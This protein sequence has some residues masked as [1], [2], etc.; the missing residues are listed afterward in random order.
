MNRSDKKDEGFDIVIGNPPYGAKI[1]KDESPEVVSA[2]KQII[3]EEIETYVLFYFKG[4]KLLLNKGT[5]CYITPDSWLTNRSTSLFRKWITETADII[6]IFDYY[7]PFP[8]AKDTRVHS[9]LICIGRNHSETRIKQVFPSDFKIIYRSYKVKQEIIKSFQNSEW[10]VYLTPEERAIFNKME[11]L[12]APLVQLYNVKYGLRTGDNGKYFT[13]KTT[14]YPLIAGSDISSLYGVE[15]IPKYLKTIDGL[16]KGYFNK[17][18]VDKKVIIQYV[19]TN[20]LRID[21]RWLEAAFVDGNFIPLNSLSYI[22]SKDEKYSL[23]YALAIINS[24]L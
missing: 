5:L 17:Y 9:V 16:S 7:K 24:Y 21:A 6:A 15:W 12:S 18:Y 10:R 4:L 3:S 14:N 13:D 20:S 8:T 1:N 11:N 22:Y 2:Y 23:K 19:R